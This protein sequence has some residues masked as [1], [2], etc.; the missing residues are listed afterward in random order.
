M[1]LDMLA[2]DSVVDIDSDSSLTHRTDSPSVDRK[3]LPLSSRAAVSCAATRNSP[4]SNT[5]S[6]GASL[7]IDCYPGTPLVPSSSSPSAHSAIII[8]T[9]SPL[10]ASVVDVDDVHSSPSHG[11]DICR[12]SLSPIASDIGDTSLIEDIDDDLMNEALMLS[13]KKLE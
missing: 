13:A 7:I 9:K 10:T 4:P 8:E 12:Q 1:P 5:S 3:Q 11:G 2:S 6:P